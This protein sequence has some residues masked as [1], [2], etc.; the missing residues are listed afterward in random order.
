MWKAEKVVVFSYQGLGLWVGLP[1]LLV[2][3]KV[4]SLGV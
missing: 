3:S 4:L 1:Y 2:L